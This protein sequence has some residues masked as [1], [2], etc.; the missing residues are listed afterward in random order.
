M[1]GEAAQCTRRMLLQRVPPI[2]AGL[3]LGLTLAHGAHAGSERAQPKDNPFAT[4]QVAFAFRLLSQLTAAKAGQNI[5]FSPLSVALALA[6]TAAGARGATQKAILRTLGL[7]TTTP[8]VLNRS[9]A[10][11]LA[12]IQSRDPKLKLQIADSF[13]TRLG[14]K[15]RPQFAQTLRAVYN[16][17]IASV[18]FRTP[19]AAA[20][21]NS[22]VS[23]KTH[24]LIPQIVSGSI[25]ADVL[26]YLINAVYFHG[27][28]SAPFRGGTAP[29]QFTLLSGA[30]VQTPLMT[31]R[32]M[33]QHAVGP[34][35]EAIRLPYGNGTIAMYVLLPAASG[36]FPTFLRSLNSAVLEDA[37]A[38]LAPQQGTIQLPRFTTSYGTDL[39]PA[40]T[41]LG[42]G[43]AFGPSADLSGMLIDAHTAID[44]VL[45]RALIAVN[46][47]GTTAAAVTGV[48]GITAVMPSE[49][50]MTVNR[51]F[52]LV[53]R[54]E[55]TGVPL[56]MGSIV[57]PR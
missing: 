25:P 57:D 51:P 19:N 43:Q 27:D 54:D 56:F 29:Q 49:F 40:L 30:K 18:D 11:L 38:A 16:A 17:D 3:G 26:L 33:F 31:N 45:H 15:V 7:G 44:A 20:V 24:G 37:I 10:A 22:W 39:R 41:A 34:S 6:M 35:L 48:I 52:F 21:I 14:L 42:M 4:A 53:L 28:W 46:E 5:I 50:T 23:R 47:E 2:A 13:W 9:S 12:A 55:R 1:N 36:A 32:G 8:A